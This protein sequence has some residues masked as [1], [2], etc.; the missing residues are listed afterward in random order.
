MDNFESIYATMVLIYIEMGGDDVL[1]ELIRLALELQVLINCS[2]ILNVTES[3][4][5]QIEGNMYINYKILHAFLLNCKLKYFIH[6]NII[7]EMRGSVL[8]GSMARQE[9]IIQNH[10]SYQLQSEKKPNCSLA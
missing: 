3:Q 7:L 8:M 10:F 4:V 1:I 6:G 2:E 9:L 5:I